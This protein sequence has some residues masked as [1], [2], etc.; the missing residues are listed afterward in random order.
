MVVSFGVATN[1][2]LLLFQHCVMEQVT[3]P[4]AM[5]WK[6]VSKVARLLPS[7]LLYM[8]VSRRSLVPYIM[9]G[10]SISCDLRS[11]GRASSRRMDWE[12]RQHQ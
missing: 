8:P 11:D 5:A 6:L 3:T 12:A 10:A 7:S 1:F 9:H 2:V 4:L